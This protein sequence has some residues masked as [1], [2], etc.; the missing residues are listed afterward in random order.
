MNT[1]Y[2]YI[3][4]MRNVLFARTISRRLAAALFGRHGS[5]VLASPEDLEGL[6]ARRR[7]LLYLLSQ[8]PVRRVPGNEGLAPA[9]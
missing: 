9:C 8:P 3:H 2:Y 4:E 1:D 6:A 5:I 7:K